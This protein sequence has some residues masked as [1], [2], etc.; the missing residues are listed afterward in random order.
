MFEISS[1]GQLQLSAL[2][3][4]VQRRGPRLLRWQ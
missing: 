4:H 1:E 2:H 3:L